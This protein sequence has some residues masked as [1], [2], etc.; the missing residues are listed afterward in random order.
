MGGQGRILEKE[1]HVISLGN[2]LFHVFRVSMSKVQRE[3]R[4]LPK[5]IQQ[6]HGR[7]WISDPGLQ[8]QRPTRQ[9][10]H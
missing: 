5:V 6:R 7:D 9:P 3:E 4:D 2:I 8:L 1:L 10:P